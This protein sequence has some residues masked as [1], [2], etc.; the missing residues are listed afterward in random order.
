MQT[1]TQRSQ[2]KIYLPWQLTS[3]NFHLMPQTVKNFIW[4]SSVAL[5]WYLISTQTTSA[6]SLQQTKTNPFSLVDV[7][8]QLFHP[9]RASNRRKIKS[10][11][12]FSFLLWESCCKAFSL[13]PH[14]HNENLFN[15]LQLPCVKTSFQHVLLTKKEKLPKVMLLWVK[16]CMKMCLSKQALLTLL[17][18]WCWWRVAEE[19]FKLK[20]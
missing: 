8:K 20:M 6:H 16:S 5:S 3:N 9:F 18:Q 10:F 14:H 11:V 7:Q 13:V 17:S 15:C 4:W 2:R 19:P 1:S 12:Q